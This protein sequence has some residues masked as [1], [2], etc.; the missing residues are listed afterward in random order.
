MFRFRFLFFFPPALTRPVTIFG[1][2]LP[3]GRSFDFFIRSYTHTHLSALPLRTVCTTA[4]AIRSISN[5]GSS[6]RYVNADDEVVFV[7]FFLFP[8]ARHLAL[9][10]LS[11]FFGGSF[12]PPSVFSS[13]GVGAPLFFSL[14][15]RPPFQAFPVA[16]VGWCFVKRVTLRQRHRR[17]APIFP[18]SASFSPNEIRIHPNSNFRLF[19]RWRRFSF[20]FVL[21][22]C[23]RPSV[24]PTL[25]SLYLFFSI[26]AFGET[27]R[28]RNRAQEGLHDSHKVLCGSSGSGRTNLSPYLSPN[29]F[30][31][32][33]SLLLL[34]RNQRAG[35]RGGANEPT[36]RP[37]VR[38]THLAANQPPTNANNYY[39]SDCSF[40]IILYCSP[41]SLLFPIPARVRISS[42]L[43]ALRFP[44]R[45]E[46][47]KIASFFPLF[48]PSIPLS[49]IPKRITVPSLTAIPQNVFIP[50]PLNV[51][52]RS[53]FTQTSF[54]VRGLAGGRRST[55]EVVSGSVFGTLPSVDSVSESNHAD[56]TSFSSGISLRFVISREE[57]CS[58]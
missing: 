52:R 56:G 2:S 32:L 5:A 29:P 30:L 45:T 9:L 26:L 24:C 51:P 46:A 44:N 28:S 27:S 42:L 8:A 48:L 57:R 11:F 12:L 3:V 43:R 20:P 37:T 23:C 4:A 16:M 39:N 58:S 40:L 53:H 47:F 36:D 35:E 33:L 38:P 19:R 22:F 18:C 55:D 14:L 34:R 10:F 21:H 13:F 50:W 54:A 31:R 7:F 25:F 49:T 41:F 15:L 17:P 6:G 1:C